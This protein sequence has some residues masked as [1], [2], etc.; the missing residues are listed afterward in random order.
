MLSGWWGVAADDIQ[1]SKP[2][3]VTGEEHHFLTAISPSK[4]C[5]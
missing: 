4:W 2:I 1:V 3:I 5:R